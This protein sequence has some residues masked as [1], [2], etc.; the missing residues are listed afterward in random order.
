MTEQGNAQLPPSHRAARLVILG[1]LLAALVAAPA[2]P[3]VAGFARGAWQQAGQVVAYFLTPLRG[4]AE[5]VP[6]APETPS[7]SGRSG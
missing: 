5:P 7:T 3:H 1:A 4:P 2:E 6:P